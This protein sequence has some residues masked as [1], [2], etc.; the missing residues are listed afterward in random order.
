[1]TA[2]YVA[3]AGLEAA[4]L[5]DGAVLYN[6]KTS[7]FIMLN[8]SASVMWNE[9]S[10][11]KTEETLVHRL[12]VIYPDASASSA[13]AAVS[14]L[15][16]ELADLE[17]VVATTNAAETASTPSA[18]GSQTALAAYEAPSV[19]VLDEEE[20]LKIFQMTAAEI[21]VAS[22]WWAACPAGCP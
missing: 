20:L 21:S 2:T 15:L 9:L 4:P 12:C 16:K 11:P 3:T 17:L 19:R 14:A 6:L 22:C 8:R 10:G 1:M 18:P 5:Q 13:Q 7:K